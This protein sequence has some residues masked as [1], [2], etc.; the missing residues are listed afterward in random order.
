MKGWHKCRLCLSEQNKSTRSLMS[1][2][3]WR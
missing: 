1:S 2:H 3:L